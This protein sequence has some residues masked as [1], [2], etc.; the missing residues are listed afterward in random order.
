VAAFLLA[1]V[2][3]SWRRPWL[4]GAGFILLGAAYAFAVG[5]RPDWVVAISVRCWPWER[6]SSG[7]GAR[8]S[9][10]APADSSD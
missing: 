1:I 9:L 7:A 6:S 10:N 8:P 2:V 3:L 4:G 5:F